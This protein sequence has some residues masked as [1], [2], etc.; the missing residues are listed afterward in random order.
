MPQDRTALRGRIVTSL[1]EDII[2]GELPGGARLNERE[3]SGRFDVSR[4]PVREALITLA[5]EG[6]VR[7]RPGDGAS[8]AP[9]TR[10]DVREVFEVRAALEPMAARLCALRASEDQM[11]EF[12]R[13]TSEAFEA[14]IQADPARGS[15]ANA[16]FHDLLVTAAGNDLLDAMARPM[17]GITRRLFRRTII[18]HEAMMWTDHREIVRA[19]STGDADL[20]AHLATVHLDNT[21]RHT[22]ALFETG[23]DVRGSAA[24]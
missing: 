15:T 11:R 19:I 21:R 3:L 22:F 14:E 1:R 23:E 7:M 17:M 24:Y 13:L 8:V 2:S 16:D 5:G 20:A 12:A 4:V 9:L 10:R 18:D 6:L